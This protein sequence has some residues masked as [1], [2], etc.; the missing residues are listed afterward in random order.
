VVGDAAVG[1]R[2]RREALASWLA[3]TAPGMLLTAGSITLPMVAAPWLLASVF[4]A[5]SVRTIGAALLVAQCLIAILV[6]TQDDRWPAAMALLSLLAVDAV[7]A[8]VLLGVDRQ[9]QSP[10]VAV[11]LGVVA[12]SAMGGGW[13]A[14]A[15][16]AA[17]GAGAAVAVVVHISGPWLISPTLWL[18]TS[19]S[20]ETSYANGSA[21]SAVAS[22]FPTTL[23]VES[24]FA[25]T[26][27]LQAAGSFST[28]LSVEPYIGGLPAINGSARLLVPALAVVLLG[29]CL[30]TGVSVLRARKARMAV[31]A[32]IIATRRAGRP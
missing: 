1:A 2:E 25:G 4:V 7:G 21:I 28:L 30:G 24:S 5:P 31:A 19:L 32:A 12:M 11:A 10:A 20:V 16:T 15:S 6:M 22:S 3:L 29:I 9:V 18:A 26:P 23:S 13:P 8:G 14:L 17:I 27:V